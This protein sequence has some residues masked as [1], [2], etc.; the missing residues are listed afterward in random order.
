MSFS[1]NEAIPINW[2]LSCVYRYIHIERFY[3]FQ[4][5]ILIL[6]KGWVLYMGRPVPI[7]QPAVCNPLFSGTF[8]FCWFELEKTRYGTAYIAPSFHANNLQF[9]LQMLIKHTD[10]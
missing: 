3:L 5:P 10:K 4:I 6:L 8:L 2:H 1:E 9:E 7:W